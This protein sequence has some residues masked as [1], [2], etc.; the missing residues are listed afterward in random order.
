MTAVANN[1]TSAV[2]EGSG[3]FVAEEQPAALV[4]QLLKF[5]EANAD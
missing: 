3:H 1:V 4:E 2:I 5:F